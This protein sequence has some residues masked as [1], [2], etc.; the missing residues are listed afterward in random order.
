MKVFIKSPYEYLSHLWDFG[1]GLKRHP[2]NVKHK[3]LQLNC[4][5]DEENPKSIYNNEPRILT[6]TVTVDFKKFKQIRNYTMSRIIPILICVQVEGLKNML[7]Q[8]GRIDETT[9]L[10]KYYKA[11]ATLPIPEHPV[12]LEKETMCNHW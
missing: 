3:S 8:F 6:S 9:K 11:L 12:M 7:T 2:F 5:Y 4:K 10:E 1:P